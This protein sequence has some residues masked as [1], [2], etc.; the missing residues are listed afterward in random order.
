MNE[1]TKVL[2]DLI[3]QWEN[4]PPLSTHQIPRGPV[5]LEEMAEFAFNGALHT[6]DTKFKVSFYQ[7][8]IRNLARAI[9]VYENA[10]EPEQYSTDPEINEFLNNTDAD[11]AKVAVRQSQMKYAEKVPERNEHTEATDKLMKEL[12]KQSMPPSKNLRR[13]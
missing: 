11:E 5:T 6:N 10:L 7:D 3:E 4:D 9:A 12:D 8:V 1:T 13:K 2:Q